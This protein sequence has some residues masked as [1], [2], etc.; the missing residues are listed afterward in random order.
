MFK[1]RVVY[2]RKW[3]KVSKEEML[4][5]IWNPQKPRLNATYT[6]EDLGSPDPAM[7]NAVSEKKVLRPILKEQRGLSK[8][9][10]DDSVRLGLYYVCMS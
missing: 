6:R 2:K 9:H 10:I 4:R 3:K 7:T 1:C 8:R 5:I